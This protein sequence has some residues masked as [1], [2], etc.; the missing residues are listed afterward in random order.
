MGAYGLV[1]KCAACWYKTLDTPPPPRY[2]LLEGGWV[3]LAKPRTGEMSSEVG[4]QALKTLTEKGPK[5]QRAH[6]VYAKIANCLK[7]STMSVKIVPILEISA[8]PQSIPIPRDK[9]YGPGAGG[10]GG[11]PG[12]RGFPKPGQA[13]WATSAAGI[14]DTTSGTAFCLVSVACLTSLSRS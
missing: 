9:I 6:K 4:D 3:N 13:A 11:S 2:R 7:S 14:H 5:R 8:A 12:P 10:G 1:G